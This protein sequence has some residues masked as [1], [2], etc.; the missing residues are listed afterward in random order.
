MLPKHKHSRYSKFVGL[1]IVLAFLVVALIAPYIAPHDQAAILGD[2]WGPPSSISYLGQ[3]NL[4]RDMF[5]R[6]IFGAR[7]TVGIATITSMVAVI[8]GCTFGFTSAIHGGWFDQIVS[9]LFEVLMSVPSLILSLLMLAVLGTSIP[10]LIG[11]ISVLQA[12]YVYRLSRSVAREVVTMEYFEAAR[13]RGERLPW[14]MALEIL[15]NSV[16]PLVA[17]IGVRFVFTV[18]FVSTLSFL[19]L[20]VQPPLADWGGMVRDNAQAIAF[21]GLAPLYPAIAIALLSIG[22]NLS[23]DGFVARRAEKKNR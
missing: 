8:I 22:V 9:R 11:T 7:L 12:P 4:G 6:L 21:G 3:D 19:G 17:E 23:I 16:A 1:T 18:L 10:V 14:L 5:S 13:L 2:V 20:G 15:P